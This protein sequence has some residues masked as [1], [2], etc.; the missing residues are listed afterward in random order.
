MRAID[1]TGQTV[2]RWAVLARAENSP[3]GGTRWRCRCA[4]GV[5]RVINGIVLR[6]GRSQSCGCLKLEGLAARSTKHGHAA[7]AGA[8]PTYH[9]WAGMWARSTN[10]R[11]GAFGYYGGRGLVVDE[12]WRDFG[13]FLADMGE[14]PPGTSLERIDNDRGYGPG[15]CRWATAVEQARNQ[16]KNRI[17]TH[18]GGRS[19]TVAEW[20]ES[21]GMNYQTLYDR[22][23]QGWSDERALTTPVRQW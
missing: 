7:A 4:C 3:A 14:K 2:G 5:E 18:P 1:L 13:V 8:S 23:R 15:N 10:P 16:R 17:L 19:A 11:H 20:A 9:S 6:D 12:A 22:L 21:L